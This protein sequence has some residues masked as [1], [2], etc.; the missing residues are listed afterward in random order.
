MFD[1]TD[2]SSFEKVPKWATKLSEGGAAE[3]CV[4]FVVGT[5]SDLIVN[6]A[7]RAAQPAE[8]EAL[9]RSLKGSYFETSSR[10]GEGVVEVFEAMVERYAALQ[11]KDREKNRPQQT[12][13][14]L[15]VHEAPQK[16]PNNQACAC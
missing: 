16:D 9:A 12:R 1:L 3:G 6:G 7:P 15:M 5:K 11:E 8:C 2:R 10:S 14:G 4:V 13:S